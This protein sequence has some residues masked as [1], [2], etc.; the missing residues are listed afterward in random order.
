M[1]VHSPGTWARASCST[2]LTLQLRHLCVTV[3]LLLQVGVHEL[4]GHGS[5]K[6]FHQGAADTAALLAA[7]TLHPIS[8]EPVRGPFYAAGAT[9]DSTF[10]KLA[11]A[12][13]E[14]RCCAGGVTVM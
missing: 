4:L 8:G 2:A 12:Y 3:T 14:C 7:G 9:W 6:L 5:G 11:S 1:G 10:G 13:E